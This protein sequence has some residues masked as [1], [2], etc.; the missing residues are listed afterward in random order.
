MD[1][2]SLSHTTWN[3]KYHMVFAPKFRRK[4]IYGGLRQDMANILSMLLRRKEVH[5]VEA[6]ICPDHVHMPVEILP[7][8]SVSD[9][10]GY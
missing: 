5:I 1:N 2:N 3:C 9:F 4:I 8:M 6:E 7:K 10:V